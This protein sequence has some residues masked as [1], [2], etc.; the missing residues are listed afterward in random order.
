MPFRV[1][2]LAIAAFVVG[3]VELIVGG[4]LELIAADLNVSVSAAGHFITVFSIAFAVSAP[5]LMNVTAKMDRKKLYVISLFVFMIANLIV[6]M[7]SSYNVILAARALS[8]MSGSIIIVLS[9]MMA[10]Q[11]VTPSHKARAIG[12]I[13]MGISGS[14][15]LGVPLGMV[16]GNAY[17]WRAPFYFI[18]LLSAIAML[19][20]QLLM[21]KTAPN[22]V[23]PLR[24]QLASLKDSKIVSGQLISFL[25][26]T[27]HL[28]LY[29]YFAPYVQSIFNV[30]ASA[31]SIIYF[32]FGIAAVSGGGI[33]GWIAD[34]I[35][36][37][38][39]L[40][41][42]VPSFALSMFVLPLA[43]QVSLYVFLAVVMIWS[44]LSWAISPAQQTYLMQ[45]APE[46]ADIQ[47]S[48]NT[49]IMHLGIAC[50]SFVG[51][52]AIKE[53]SVAINPW[54][55]GCI[56][57]LGLVSALFSLSR[58]SRASEQPLATTKLAA[59]V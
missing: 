51:G 21:E 10:S 22:P 50:G 37:H 59:E 49:S 4:I 24:K 9:I 45:S 55:G 56:A 33:G 5:I 36:T 47:L 31:M 40:L 57:L 34:R 6:A 27:G 3:T 54:I 28:T 32:L 44:A 18:A 29:A 38:K 58:R 42:I 39:A 52:I 17:G 1:Y 20:I 48:L 15:V 26:L 12:T 53:A 11:L 8:A 7:S 13:F 30:S 23:I 16:L 35:G 14:L 19:C 46:T 25:L 43:A 2:I 41:I